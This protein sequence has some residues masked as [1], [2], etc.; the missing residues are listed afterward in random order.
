MES[1][2]LISN[3]VMAA[4]IA[5]KCRADQDL[6]RRL[7]ANCREVLS[8]M[9]DEGLADDVNVAVVQ[10]A[11][12]QVHVVLPD[13]EHQGDMGSDLLSDE[14]MAQVSGGEIIISVI[15]AGAIGV[16]VAGA[17]AGTV[18]GVVLSD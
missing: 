12:G 2:N 4:I 9:S 10:N 17:I 1:A 14:K 7:Q 13:Y 6:S 8:S 18:A 15:V 5:D 3:E 11:P 16:G